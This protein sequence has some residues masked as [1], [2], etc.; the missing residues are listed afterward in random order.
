MKKR[1]SRIFFPGLIIGMMLMY[2]CTGLEQIEFR[3]D[4]D[5]QQVEVLID[6]D[7]FTSYI[8]PQQI[9][10][11]VLWPVISNGGN[12]L[13]RSYPMVII[14][15][16]SNPGYSTYWHARGYGLF[17]ANTLEQMVFSK[18]SQELNFHLTRGQKATF[19]YRLVVDSMNLNDEQINQLANDFATARE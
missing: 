6:G 8:Y 11:P 12:M 15:H 1:T 4:R 9:Q 5:K 16:P 7:L 14:D 3:V 10:K 13:T 19:R 18:G 17:A 2:Q